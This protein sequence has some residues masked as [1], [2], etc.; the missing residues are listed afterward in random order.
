MVEVFNSIGQR[1]YMDTPSIYPIEINALNDSG[2]YVV[3]VVTG[4][5]KSYQDKI[6]IVE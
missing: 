3:R 1:V 2:V 6:I 5:G 4:N